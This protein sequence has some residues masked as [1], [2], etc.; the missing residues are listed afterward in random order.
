MFIGKSSLDDLLGEVLKRLLKSRKRISP[1]KGEAKEL[2]GVVLELTNPR[3][4]LSQTEMKGTLFSCLGELLWYLSESNDVAP[5][6]YYLNR[7][8]EFAE[9]DGTVWGAYGP[10]I[11]NMRGINQL[12]LIIKRLE[13]N[14]DSRKAVVQLFN[15]EDIPT[16]EYSYKDIPCTCVFQF[17]IRSDKLDMITSM[18]SN[19]AFIGLPHDVFAFTMLQEIVARSLGKEI[20]TYKHMV[21]SL[22]LYDDKIA[23]ARAYLDEGF[24]STQFQMP[25]MPV[26]DPWTSLG[27]VVENERRIRLNEMVNIDAISVE[28]FWHDL[29]KA[30]AIYRLAKDASNISADTL[31][32]IAEIKASMS[33]TT[34]NQ[35]IRKRERVVANGLL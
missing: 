10:R 16:D 30:L 23:K 4:R 34:Y 24:Q 7:Y 14:P 18:R 25:P 6:Q 9:P 19:D 17:M 12:A 8:N 33:C 5:I 29:I 13:K 2:T 35:Y 21:G 15:A 32:Q 31:K 26:G 3:A 11:F 28:P 22:H 1:T 20:G 27:I